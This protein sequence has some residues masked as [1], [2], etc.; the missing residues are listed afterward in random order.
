[1]SVEIDEEEVEE[2]DEHPRDAPSIAYKIGMN[3]MNSMLFI[4]ISTLISQDNF[5]F[6]VYYSQMSTLWI[7]YVKY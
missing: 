3:R 7:H 1:M 2:E 6:F 4:H 5:L